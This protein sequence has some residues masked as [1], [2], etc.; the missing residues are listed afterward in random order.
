[1]EKLND[2]Y[3][4]LFG[5]RLYGMFFLIIIFILVL[6]G[7]ALYL[8]K[9]NK[10]LEDI[11]QPNSEKKVNKFSFKKKEAVIEDMVE[12][13]DLEED[14]GETTT[15]EDEISEEI[16]DQIEEDETEELEEVVAPVIEAEEKPS[17]QNKINRIYKLQLNQIPK[18]L[19][20]EI[21]DI[22]VDADLESE[23]VQQS[24]LYRVLNGGINIIRTKKHWNPQDFL[25]LNSSSVMFL[26]QIIMDRVLMYWESHLENPED[27]NDGILQ[28]VSHLAHAMDAL[29]GGTMDIT[30]NQWIKTIGQTNEIEGYTEHQTNMAFLLAEISE[31]V[32]EFYKRPDFDEVKD[33][34]LPTN[35]IESDVQEIDTILSYLF[36]GEPITD[37]YSDDSDNLISICLFF[38][39]AKISSYSNSTDVKVLTE[40]DLSVLRSIC[41][42][43]ETT[44]YPEVLNMYYKENIPQKG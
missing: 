11:P 36:N 27:N 3:V 28:V 39:D 38:L 30:K 44:D 33:L 1:M 42:L 18:I 15:G 4:D 21:E 16:D 19:Q 43:V 40:Y 8:I 26:N 22:F 12:E 10:Q 13:D 34:S 5:F 7:V 41:M 17:W 25:K 6:V 9:E 2:I 35:L 32:K 37:M 23:E 20:E 14:S 31:T 24:D 29:N